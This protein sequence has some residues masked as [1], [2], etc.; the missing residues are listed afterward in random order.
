MKLAVFGSRSIT[1][2]TFVEK[3]LKEYIDTIGMPNVVLMGGAAGVQEIVKEHLKGL[4]DVIIF[5][6]WHM[7]DTKLGFVTKYLFMRNKQIIDNS[8]RV[9]VFSKE[10]EAD[11]EV[12]MAI[13]FAHKRGKQVDVI[14]YEEGAGG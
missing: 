9:L 13:E 5:K 4:T 7:V 12:D 2:K 11:S 8:H 14:N 1:D 3:S 10:G 6:Q